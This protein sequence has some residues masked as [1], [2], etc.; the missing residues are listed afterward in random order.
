[1]KIADH[2]IRTF[3]LILLI[4]LAGITLHS[5]EA[6]E[7]NTSL[8]KLSGQN[9]TEYLAEALSK[10]YPQENG[11]FKVSLLKAQAEINVPEGSVE[12]KLKDL[13]GTGLRS[14]IMLKY[15][16]HVDGLLIQTESIPVEIQMMKEVLVSKR[17]VNRGE[18]ILLDDLSLEIRDVL[19]L[20]EPPVDPSSDLSVYE[21]QYTL[22]Q[23]K[24]LTERNIRMRP[25]VDRGDIVTGWLKRGLLQINLK[26]EV[27]EEAAP[28]Q[29]VRVR[30]IKSKKYLRGIVYDENSVLIP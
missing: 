21:I 22:M 2:S 15:E 25:V 16:L 8:K 13:P 26:V 23:G 9:L 18:P 30:N 28:G 3:I 14:R 17:R 11:E 29:L 20:R 1:M 7:Q 27:M 19:G 5:E 10:A 4:V 6:T 12:I 24:I